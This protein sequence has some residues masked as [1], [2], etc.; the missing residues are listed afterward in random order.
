MDNLSNG[1]WIAIVGIIVAAVIGIIQI[2][3]NSSTKTS[4]LKVNQSSGALS[5][6]NQKIKIEVEQREK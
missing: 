3:R 4:G 6:G 2:L 5:K 1:E